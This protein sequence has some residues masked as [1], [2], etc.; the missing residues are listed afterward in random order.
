MTVFYEWDVET[1]TA[2]ET[3]AHEEDEVMEHYH[4]SS[5]K[6][7]RARAA[8]KPDEGC[9]HEVALVRDDD[10]GRSWAYVEDG[11]LPEFFSDANGCNTA[12]VPQRFV[13]EVVAAGR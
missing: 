7:A 4:C 8:T 2:T 6:E 1:V 12:K 3:D 9:K 10:E 13:K 5:Y 11:V